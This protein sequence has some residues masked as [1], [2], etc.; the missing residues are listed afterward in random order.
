MPDGA[1]EVSVLTPESQ[2]LH[3]D[4]RA[5][6]LRS[7][8]GDLTVLNGHT[9]LVTDVVPGRVRV[10]PAEGDPVH[11]A[12]HGGYLQV[13]TGLGLDA[14]EARATR[15]TLLAGTAELASQIDV[16]RAERAR[17]EAEA[18]VEEL[19]AA[20]GRA[21]T[22]AGGAGGAQ[23]AGEGATAEDL[24]LSE[25]EAALERAKVRLEV[26]GAGS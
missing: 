3:V 1:F 23:G 18:R 4:A 15:V 9:P 7:S 8:D 16:A 14:S 19:R 25:A 5:V 24:E 10:D 20:Q 11:M 17:A 12:V 13:E 26:A 21:G 22:T 2:L 6:V